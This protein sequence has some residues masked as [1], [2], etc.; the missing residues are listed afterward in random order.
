M[1]EKDIFVLRFLYFV[2]SLLSCLNPTLAMLHVPR[3]PGLWV[4]RP[5]SFTGFCWI[6]KWPFLLEI[7]TY[8]RLWCW[9]FLLQNWAVFTFHG[10]GFLVK[11]WTSTKLYHAPVICFLSLGGSYSLVGPTNCEREETY[12][13]CRVYFFLSLRWFPSFQNPSTHNNHYNDHIFPKDVQELHKY[14]YVRICTYNFFFF[15]T[16]FLF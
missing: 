5:N 1:L 14:T 3:I 12:T 9:F 4:S 6:F 16:H 7:W 8:I 13:Q 2:V 10:M 11:F 15:K